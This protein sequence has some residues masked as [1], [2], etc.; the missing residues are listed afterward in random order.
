LIVVNVQGK[1]DQARQM[2]ET[3]ANSCSDLWNYCRGLPPEVRYT[4]RVPLKEYYQTVADE[5]WEGIAAGRITEQSVPQYQSLWRSIAAYQPKS[6]RESAYYSNILETMKSLADAR[7]YRMVAR[8]RMLSPI[9][10]LVL[11]S[12]C[13]LTILF[14]YFFWVDSARTQ[15]VLTLF[16]TVFIALNMLLVRLFENP[17][18]QEFLVKQGAFALKSELLNPTEEDIAQSKAHPI[19]IKEPQFTREFEKPGY[20]PVQK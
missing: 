7:R 17:Y 2:A 1:F 9:I 6:N 3:E 15:I 4:I 18:R 19:V 11:V 12:G 14:S 10:W 13:V 8:R 16:V 20:D 5:D